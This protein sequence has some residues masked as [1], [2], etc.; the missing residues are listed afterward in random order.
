MKALIPIVLL[1]A[2]FASAQFQFFEQFF[3]GGQQNK[4]TQEKQNV[5]SDSNW[6]RQNW[7]GDI[8]SP[9]K[10]VPEMTMADWPTI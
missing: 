4:G 9:G 3:H 5:P 1:L 8:G 7:D 6:Y 2:G 10:L